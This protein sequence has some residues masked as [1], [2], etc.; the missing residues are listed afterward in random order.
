MARSL[1]K[2]VIAAALAGVVL[3]VVPTQAQTQANLS[4]KLNRLMQGAKRSD[5]VSP[6]D[7]LTK[8]YDHALSQGAAT[9]P[10]QRRMALP[11]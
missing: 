8:S 6:L 10:E 5:P 1:C 3:V 2:E 9:A 11:R 7:D 4:E